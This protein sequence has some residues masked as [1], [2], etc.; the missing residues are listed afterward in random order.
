MKRISTLS[1][2]F[3]VTIII[4]LIIIAP[5]SVIKA[6]E[7]E[8]DFI[9]KKQHQAG[10]RL[11]V[12]SNRGGTPPDS[13]D[14]GS[15][16]SKVKEEN[17]YFEAFYGYRLHSS[18]ILEGSLGLVNR[19]SV[20]FTENEIENVGNLLI[21]SV[22]AKAKFYPLGSY[23]FKIQPYLMGGGGIYYARRSVQFTSNAYYYDQ[24]GE[25]TATNFNY[26]FGGGIDFPISSIIGLEFNVKYLSIDFSDPLLSIRNYDALAFSIGVKYLYQ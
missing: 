17:V 24:Y 1:I 25:K 10:I 6:E 11:G 16:H 2:Y 9:F 19:G 23:S 20:T 15:F 12:W 21:Y 8:S 13:S 26:C 5:G 7:A 22:L 3:I 18:F 4:S 14:D